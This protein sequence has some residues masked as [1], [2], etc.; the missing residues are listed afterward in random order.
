VNKQFTFVICIGFCVGM[1]LV[2]DGNPGLADT[3]PDMSILRSFKGS[4]YKKKLQQ[5]QESERLIAV[6]EEQSPELQKPFIENAGKIL[7]GLKLK[8][9]DKK[10]I[11]VFLKKVA[12]DADLLPA[13][14]KAIDRFFKRGLSTGAKIGIGVGS[15]AAMTALIAMAI[16]AAR[17]GIS[18]GMS[19]ALKTVGGFS[20]PKDQEVVHGACPDNY[21]TTGGR[22]PTNRENLTPF[23]DAVTSGGSQ[24]GSSPGATVGGDVGASAV[25]ADFGG[26]LLAGAGAGTGS[27]AVGVV[28]SPGDGSGSGVSA[29]AE[30]S[31]AESVANGLV[32]G[33]TGAGGGAENYVIT[34]QDKM[35]DLSCYDFIDLSL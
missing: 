26:H 19:G 24:A 17:S 4:A 12:T 3:S 25:T 29:S 16:V 7:L 27:G 33:D 14:K 28:P 13:D 23:G 20:M 5:H 18:R 35:I 32:S 9:A 15:A 30:A 6:L 11:Q 31:V 34:T 8:A 10:A 21:Y 2:V 1:I 22:T